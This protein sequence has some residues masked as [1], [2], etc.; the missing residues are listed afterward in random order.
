MTA[1]RRGQAGFTLLEVLLSVAVL[2]V[3]L[4]PVLAW[5]VLSLQRGNDD[6]VASDTTAFSRINQYLSRDIA[7]AR[8]LRSYEAATIS[9]GPS[10]PAIP[11]PSPTGPDPV[12]TR[13][14]L[15]TTDSD[16]RETG[17]LTERVTDPGDPTG[18]VEQLVRRTCVAG[19][20]VSS[21][22]VLER[23]GS[24][25]APNPANVSPAPADVPVAVTCQAR[26]GIDEDC[27]T[28]TLQ[29]EGERGQ[30]V[31]VRASRR[32]SA[33]RSGDLQPVA[34]IR[35]SPSCTGTRDAN[36]S[37]TVVL[38]GSRSTSPAGTPIVR[39]SFSGAAVPTQSGLRTA[40]ITFT[41]TNDLPEWN[42]GIKGCE[43]LATLEIEDPRGQTSARDQRIV[44]LNST[45]NLTVRPDAVN[46]F[47]AKDVC[48]DASGTADDDDPTG[49]GLT[50]EWFFDDPV[51]G[52][53]NTATGAGI[54]V[55]DCDTESTLAGVVAHR[56][57]A[58]TG[59]ASRRAKLTVT[60]NEGAVE[61]LDI[62]VQ[63]GNQ[64]PVPVITS[65]TDRLEGIPSG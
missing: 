20:Q 16:G 63:I 49:A 3:V 50:F 59:S 27:G 24:L 17:Y 60:D 64:P 8:T 13:A 32:I 11:C 35:C 41:C 40:P 58:L 43:Y 52:A 53:T 1:P 38:D 33:P 34:D 47:R 56:Y 62:P 4:I 42:P 15:V 31:T 65:V 22:V 37:F 7:S 46:S 9:V 45:P 14:W 55:V 44:V 6:S 2:A 54:P 26:P 39:W 29:V 12:T 30:P 28:V 51:P 18:T 5:T 61:T 25:F 10:N 21:E 48:F 19:A 23:L 36:K 57:T